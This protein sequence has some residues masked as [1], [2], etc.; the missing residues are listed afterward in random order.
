[1]TGIPTTLRRSGATWVTTQVRE[2]SYIHSRD[3]TYA[4]FAELGD[5]SHYVSDGRLIPILFGC[6]HFIADRRGITLPRCQ[7]QIAL[8][9]MLLGVQIEVASAQ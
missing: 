5:E 9:T 4:M 6:S 8:Q 2:L 3:V 1:M 7:E